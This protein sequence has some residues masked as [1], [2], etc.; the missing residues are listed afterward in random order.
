MMMRN[1]SAVS[2]NLVSPDNLRCWEQ[3]EYNL[4]KYIS[5]ESWAMDGYIL[6]ISLVYQL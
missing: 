2:R 6:Y 5:Q 3:T 4:S 1:L